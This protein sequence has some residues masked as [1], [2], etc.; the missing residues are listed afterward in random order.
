MLECILRKE[1]ERERERGY[2]STVGNTCGEPEAF[3]AVL[4]ESHFQY[5]G[6]IQLRITERV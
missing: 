1:R 3:M 6:K 5:P 2:E 4:K